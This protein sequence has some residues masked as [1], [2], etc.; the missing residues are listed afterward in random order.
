MHP[1][2]RQLL[3]QL[4]RTG[5]LAPADAE[6]CAAIRRG[7]GP[8]VRQLLVQRGVLTGGEIGPTVGTA[9]SSPGS[10]GPIAPTYHQPLPPSSDPGAFAPTVVP[11]VPPSSGPG[12]FA[13]TVVPPVPPRSDP[14]AFAPTVMPSSSDPSA[15]APTAVPRQPA[16]DPGD[17]IPTVVPPPGS[18]VAP[19]TGFRAPRRHVPSA[20]DV[21]TAVGPPPPSSGMNPR[22][23]ASSSGRHAPGF[24]S[25]PAAPAVPVASRS[26]AAP[27][28]ASGSR[29]ASQSGS[30]AIPDEVAVAR[31]DP[32][33]GQVGRYVLVDELGRGGMGVVWRCYDTE[34]GRSVALKMILDPAR[35]GEAGVRRLH[36]EARAAAALRHPG[37][38]AVHEVGEH[39]GKPYLVMDF[40]QGEDLEKR[41]GRDPLPPRR[42]AEVIHDLADALHH[43]HEAGIV[44]RDVKPPNVLIDEGGKVHLVDF[45][46]ARTDDA[47]TQ[48]TLTG[49]MIGTP[50][51]ISPEQAKGDHGAVGPPADVFSLGGVLYW[52]LT[53]KPP[54]DGDNL[55]GVLRKVF[56]EDPDPPRQ[57][58]PTVHPDL[59]TIAMRCMEKELHRRYAT[60]ADVKRELRRFLDGE[61]I[62]A[63]PLSR[64]DKTRRWAR[65]NPARVVALALGG[66]L[67]LA[68]PVLAVGSWLATERA[69]DAAAAEAR[70]GIERGA[71]EAAERAWTELDT[72][73]QEAREARSGE[74]EAARRD[75]MDALLALGLAAFGES[76]RFEGVAPDEAD[77]AQLMF[78]AAM[79][80]GRIALQAEQWAVAAGAFEKAA[81]LGVADDEAQAALESVAT[82]RGELLAS[83]R[84]IIEDVLERAR[85]GELLAVRE[86]Y[87]DALFTIVRYP[88]AQTIEILAE[89][90]DR[91]TTELREVSFAIFREAATPDAEERRA[92]VRPIDDV[93]EILAAVRDAEPG[94]ELQQPLVSRLGR[95]ERRVE[96]REARRRQSL[97]VRLVPSVNVILALAQT[98]RIDG[99]RRQTAQLCGEALGRLGLPEA[100]PALRRHL[101]V[102]RDEVRAVVPA[103]A[104]IQVGGQAEIDLV[105]RLQERL[106]SNGPFASAVGRYLAARR[107]A[108]VPPAPVAGATPGAT[109]TSGT[110]KP[111]P[112]TGADATRPP[113]PAPPDGTGPQTANEWVDR[114]HDLA[115]QGR[116]EEA[117]AAYDRAIELD[118]RNAT[119]FNNRGAVK[120]DRGDVD[121]A[122]ADYTR[123][124]EHDPS[125]AH[126]WANRG[127][128]RSGKGDHEG[129]IGDLERAVKLNPNL[130]L[131]WC[132]LGTA[133][134]EAGDLE[135][136]LR[137]ADRAVELGPSLDIVFSHRGITHLE[138][139]D[140]ARALADF[141]R[142]LEI[143]PR[144]AESHCDRALAK[145]RLGDQEGSYRDLLRAVELDPALA[146]GWSNLG[147]VHYDRGDL[148]SAVRACSRAIELD[149]TEVRAWL[150]R[151]MTY[152]YLNEPRKAIA[153]LDR[154]L[155]LFPRSLAAIVTRASC[156]MDLGELARSRADFDRA[157]QIAPD[158]V[159]A[160][161]NR[162]VLCVRMGDR[163]GASRDFERALQLA[164]EDASV[165]SNR[166][167]LR[168]Q[169]GDAEGALADW[170]KAVELAPDD[171]MIL[172]NRAITL[173]NR[174]DYAGALADCTRAVEVD[175][176][177]ASAWRVLGTVRG[178]TNDPRAAIEAFD[179]AIE[180]EP[181]DATAWLFRGMTKARTGD[182][183]GAK[184]DLERARDLYPSG[185]PQQA[186]VQQHLDGLR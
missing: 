164:P 21:G 45:G 29:P 49:Q 4:V 171:A 33:R 116:V 53:G 173:R 17:F 178:E 90:L 113:D 84:R 23:S 28:S 8:P 16:S 14:A 57:L 12:A 134:R 54:F 165:W 142:A 136:A 82:A 74:S 10:S 81:S 105:I 31:D 37:I 129:A 13:P 47:R 160:L 138:R 97:G 51:F 167:L 158:D 132:F 18:S 58:D 127:R 108:A 72:A 42:I 170:N 107:G 65:R 95:L 150:N 50:Q 76:R 83:H 43:A 88:E 32:E 61:A 143:D 75:R 135:G 24:A 130:A 182:R 7:G 133:R 70:A 102:E 155:E 39:E 91:V 30:R 140:P 151:G 48:L 44:H 162:G 118:P 128:Y 175:P 22:G 183:A 115:A 79:D 137:D 80:L 6:A 120:A 156:W 147:A 103:N 100:I 119:A 149:P 11:P 20:D 73:R 104:L 71:R 153:D 152:R 176:L 86:S 92:G 68:L 41:H 186:Q 121:G 185:S 110:G 179:R 117:L 85:R 55:L 163:E 184:S 159:K 181:R 25:A 139:R 114:G 168:G 78:R 35:M 99:A 174:R 9:P 77:A 34:L 125:N 98:E 38:C 101:L 126:V 141:E 56:T 46:I 124:I 166:A 27:A 177:Y 69:A 146:R 122:I 180:L 60:C 15:F 1:E 19:S 64:V 93:E 154:T 161:S 59:D 111:P 112:F 87:E 52:L 94:A 66:F 62:T 89:E 5:R 40:I 2:E 67:V 26:G 144:C 148:Q 36:R 145:E 106:G 169:T 123:S 157:L 172:S 131:A 3:D 63:R 109:S 96:E